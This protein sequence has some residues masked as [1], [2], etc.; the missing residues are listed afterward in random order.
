VTSSTGSLFDVLTVGRFNVPWPRLYLYCTHVCYS[1]V[2][3][4]LLL[5]RCFCPS[6]WLS[7]I[8][9]DFLF[10]ILD[11]TLICCPSK[12]NNKTNALL[13]LLLLLL[14]SSRQ[15]RKSA[16]NSYVGFIKIRSFIL[17]P[18]TQIQIQK[19]ILQGITVC[20]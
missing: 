14:V 17:F 11:E 4:F 13:L 15:C 3:L 18:P 12:Q 10:A 19:R 5:L 9:V 16:Q 2:L 20:A 1:P 6:M 8:I 7:F